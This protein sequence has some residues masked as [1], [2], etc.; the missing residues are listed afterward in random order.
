MKTGFDNYF[1]F[2]VGNIFVLFAEPFK[3]KV[4]CVGAGN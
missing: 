3:E 2:M 4:C 1:S